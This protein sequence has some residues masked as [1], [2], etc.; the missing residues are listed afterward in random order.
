[1]PDLK[2]TAGA[3]PLVPAA[4]PDEPAAVPLDAAPGPVVPDAP[5][6]EIVAPV[7][8]DSPEPA[9]VVPEAE[10]EAVTARAKALVERSRQESSEIDRLLAG[11]RAKIAIVR[12]HLP[13]A[14]NGD[15]R[16]TAAALTALTDLVHDMLDPGR[17]AT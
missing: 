16:A 2:P 9:L 1:M 11:F 13:D 5:G 10:D 15:H 7:D 8:A 6:P 3:G 12:S 17:T 14:R 4:G